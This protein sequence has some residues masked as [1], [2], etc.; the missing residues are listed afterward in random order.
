MD[1][2]DTPRGV[3]FF[4]VF[5]PRAGPGRIPVRFRSFLSDLTKRRK[6]IGQHYPNQRIFKIY[7]RIIYVFSKIRVIYFVQVDKAE[8][9]LQLVDFNS[10][11]ETT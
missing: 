6:R 3:S 4:A 11:E 1:R 8:M 10:K 5:F 2:K 7:P 9:I